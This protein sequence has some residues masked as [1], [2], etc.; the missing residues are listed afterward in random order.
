MINFL[1]RWFPAFYLCRD[2]AAILN[3][4]KGIQMNIQEA[5]TAIQALTTQVNKIKVE[6]QALVTAVGNGGA[7]TTTQ[8]FDLALARLQEAVG[9]VDNLN[10]DAP[11]PGEPVDPQA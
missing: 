5:T 6:V 11:P 10:P 4:L 1:S 8:E 7:Q 9:D 3:L 2:I